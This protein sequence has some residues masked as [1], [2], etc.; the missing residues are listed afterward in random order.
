VLFYCWSPDVGQ[1][2][3]DLLAGGIEVSGIEH[4]DYVPADEIQVRDP[5]GYLLVIGQLGE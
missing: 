1:L 5:G 3:D 2:R 4:P